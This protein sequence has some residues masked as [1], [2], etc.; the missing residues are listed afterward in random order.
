MNVRLSL[1][2]SLHTA[3]TDD[4]RG[5]KRS[6]GSFVQIRLFRV[7]IDQC[8]HRLLF[9]IVAQ[10]ILDRSTDTSLNVLRLEIN[11]EIEES[12]H[13]DIYFVSLSQCSCSRV[14]STDMITIV[15]P[16]ISE[17]F[18]QI[19]TRVEFLQTLDLHS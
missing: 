10:T 19:R 11:L 8:L 18:V 2:F 12:D 15:D 14:D 9:F 13:T 6:D 1:S 17:M 3:L 7:G 4:I 5:E 16:H